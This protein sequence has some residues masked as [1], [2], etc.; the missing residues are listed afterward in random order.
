MFIHPDTIEQIKDRADTLSIVQKFVTLK[1]RGPRYIGI[2]PFNTAEKTPSF[3]VTPSKNIFHCFSSG[4]GGD[5]ITFLMEAQKMD[6]TEALAYL[7]NEYGIALKH[8]T[9]TEE[10]Q[11]VIDEKAEFYALNKFAA[12]QWQK[13]LFNTGLKNEYTVRGLE[14]YTGQQYW[15]QNS[16]PSIQNFNLEDNHVFK[17][18]IYKRRLSLE[19]ILQFGLGFAPDSWNFLYNAIKEEGR[20]VPSEKIGL[21]KKGKSKNYDSYRNRIIYPIHDHTGKLVAFGS[22]ALKE[23]K[24]ANGKT[25]CYEWIEGKYQF[26]KEGLKITTPKAVNSA[27]SEI[28]NKSKVLYGLHLAIKA[29]RTYDMAI[30]VEGYNDV[31]AMHQSLMPN[32]VGTCGTALTREH[33]QLL[34]R[35]TNNLTICYD[36]DAPGIKKAFEHAETAIKAGFGVQ[37]CLLPNGHDPDSFI[38][39]GKGKTHFESL[40]DHAIIKIAEYHLEAKTKDL[41]EKD[42]WL[43]TLSNTISYIAGETIRDYLVK[44]ISKIY[45]VRLPV[46]SKMVDKWLEIREKET[47]RTR[48][49][50][51]KNKVAKL[52]SD[53]TVYPFFEERFTAKGVFDKLVINKVRFVEL[54]KHFGYSRYTIEGSEAHTFVRINDNLIDH[55]KQQEIIDHLEDFIN[56]DYNFEGAGCTITDAEMLMNKFLDGIRSY[57]NADIFARVRNSDKI[58]VSKDTKDTTYFYYENGFVEINA[59]GWELKPYNQMDGGIWARQMV[60]REFMAVDPNAMGGTTIPDRKFGVFA[61]FVWCIAGKDP[62]RFLDLCAIIGYSV[63]DYYE[64]KLK[65]INLTDSSLSSESDG[66]SGKTLLLKMLANV[67]NITEINGKEFKSDDKGKYSEVDIYTQLVGINDIINKGRY[68]F[69]FDDLF[70]DVTEGCMVKKLY[71]DPFRKWLK[72]WIL[73]NAPLE[74]H[75]GSQRDRI[76]EF[77]LSQHFS[78][79]HSPE[80]EYGIWLGRDFDQKEWHYYDNFMCYCS[81]LFHMNGL[82]QP[83]NINLEERKLKSETNEYFIEFMEECAVKLKEIQLPW[84]GYT[85]PYGHSISWP[86]EPTLENI[87]IDKNAF[88][89]K[90]IADKQEMND[91]FHT[92]HIFTKWLKLYSEFRYG[93]KK[94]Y[95]TRTSGTTYVYLTQES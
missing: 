15:F 45:D 42:N 33:L 59:N 39:T 95:T 23:G 86:T 67:R 80:D 44:H 43:Q 78:T 90:M 18:L 47:E 73:S 40:T 71:M 30:V 84:F 55:V 46:Y 88:Y 75:G 64:Y 58:I 22:R 89:Y 87:P 13:A 63:H 41:L 76:I 5:A 61:H 82:S 79:K 92:L 38:R 36:G 94:P 72:I 91:R 32:T 35:Y 6:F 10:E 24:N 12:G 7:A 66:R 34:G 21:I 51:R 4:K 37:L 68:K 52:D 8:H 19:T 54:L 26:D 74:V 83:K 50:A 16:Y 11:K 81:S 9:P 49:V 31:I 29:I 69:R 3:Y 17:E 2:S 25:E 56:T 85:V 28:Y 60:D 57:F 27:E 62:G 14:E 65:A 20:V 1:S 70:N 93:V 77:E 48:I 53:P